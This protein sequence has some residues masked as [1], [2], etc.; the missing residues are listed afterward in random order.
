MDNKLNLQPMVESYNV[1]EEYIYLKDYLFIK[2]YA[3]GR[4]FAYTLQALPLARKLHNGQYRK[5]TIE[6]EG[7]QVRVPYILHPLKVCSTLM[8]LDL[9][10]PD[11]DLDI[12]YA[13]ALLHDVF[14]E[15]DDVFS[16]NGIEFCTVFH[17]PERVRNVV[18]LLSKHHGASSE[19]LQ[20]YFNCIKKDPIALLIKIADRSHNSEDLYNMKNTKKYVDETRTYF[21]D[22]KNSL[23][24]YGKQNYP[25][26]SNGITILKSKIQSLVDTT[27]AMLKKQDD[28]VREAVEEALKEIVKPTVP[29]NAASSA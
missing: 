28:A 23:C 14:E 25:V 26:L 8:S 27:V 13:C 29:P 24:T 22:H 15:T 19:E 2:G 21:L 10:M 16:E 7:I 12:L 18:I 17:F 11:E 3:T 6:V 20:H 9:D 1:E 4:K 5:G